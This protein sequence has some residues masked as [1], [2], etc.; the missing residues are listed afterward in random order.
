MLLGQ[1]L[2]TRYFKGPNYFEVGGLFCILFLTHHAD[3]YNCLRHCWQLPHFSALAADS[4][5]T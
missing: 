1:K 5:A 2:T 3:A 4:V